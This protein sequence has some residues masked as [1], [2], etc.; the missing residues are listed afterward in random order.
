VSIEGDTRPLPEP[1]IV[2]A[3]QNPVEYEGTYPLPEA[4]LD[5]F[6]FKL[7][8]GYPTAEQEQE[9]LARHDR[10]LDPH[11]L[12]STGI[13]SVATAGDFERARREVDTVRVEPPVLAY[14]VALARATRDSPSLVLGVSP[15][16]SAALL[17]ASKAWAWLSGRD[18]LT[19]DEVK[20]VVKPVL[21][22]R[23]QVRP[24]LELEGTDPDGVLD[25][26]LASVPVPR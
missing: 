12:A 22:H 15:R 18:F 21:R 6:L 10:G 16:G 19:P 14:L 9:V 26:I 8:V 3:T 23:I 24:E 5:R 4:Q 25:G 2:V 7:Q 1:F 17:H 13:T 20:A 11:D